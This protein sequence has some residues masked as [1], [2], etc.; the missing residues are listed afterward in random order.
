MGWTGF[1]AKMKDGKVF[2]SGD[3]AAQTARCLEIIESA[4]RELGL[5]RRNIV[6]TRMFVTDITLWETVGA[7]HGEFF[8]DSPPATGMYEIKA[9]I[10]PG[11][12]IEIEAD[13]IT[14]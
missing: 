12:L 13:A 8:R 5:S 1:A 14:F 9:L 11:L 3:A 4:L 10:E 7:V 6:R 2:A